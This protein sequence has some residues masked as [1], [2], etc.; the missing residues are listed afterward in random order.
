[1]NHALDHTAQS[2]YEGWEI[3][4]RQIAE[5]YSHSPLG[6]RDAQEGLAY[7]PDDIW[8]KMVA[9]NTDH[10][11]DVWASAAKCI[12][13][14][15]LVAEKDLGKEQLDAMSETEVEEALWDVVQEMCDDPA[16]LDSSALPE[17]IRV[18]AFQSLAA[19]LGSTA[20]ESLSEH[21]QYLLTR[22]VIAG[23]C[24]HKDHNYSLAVKYDITG[25]HS[26]VKFPDTSNNWFGTHNTGAAELVSYHAAYLQFF[27]I[28]R[29]SK[30]TPVSDPYVAAIRKPGV[31]HL[32][33]G[34][35][36]KQIISH[37]EKLVNNPDLWL[38]PTASCEDVTLD[39]PPFRDQFAV[40]SVHFMSS[41]LP[42]L[43]PILIVFL[44]A[45]LPAWKHFS[46]EFSTDG[47]IHSL[48]P[49][50]KLLMF[51]PPTKD[52]N[53]S[54]LGG[55]RVRASH[56]NLITGSLR[57]IAVIHRNVTEA[58][59]D[60]KLDIEEDAL[61]IM[62]SARTED[63][64]SAMQKFRN[65]LLAFKQ[66]AAEESRAKQQ[67][68]VDAAAEQL[69]EFRAIAIV[70]DPQELGKMKKNVLRQQLDIRREL[71]QVIFAK[72][73]LKDM[74]NQPQML[75]TILESD[76]RCLSPGDIPGDSSTDTQAE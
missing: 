2:Q 28:I 67:V 26:T 40:D 3:A 53:E 8:C 50:E 66:R 35:L 4:G 68:K 75:K 29:D 11:N 25:E 24:E 46:T 37:I 33:L 14:K 72:A 9:H 7:D 61:Y 62:R 54:L 34:P 20:F 1:M 30:Q 70:T 36:H 23:C 45:T 60:A 52:A 16:A 48:M 27:G 47:I 55:W 6:R 51:I 19:H 69:V 18:E 59:S 44:R 39:G 5:T 32:D 65:D 57:V 64:S 43:E 42:H 74:K 15:R 41:C 71:L 10:A 73:K 58:F 56:G 17:D 21:Q 12:E 31:N 22:T 76:E 13:K 38:D 63:A 49:A